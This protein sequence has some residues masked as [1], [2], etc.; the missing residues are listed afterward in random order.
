MCHFLGKLIISRLWCWSILFCSHSATISLHRRQGCYRVSAGTRGY[1]LWFHLRIFVRRHFPASTT[2]W[3]KTRSE[4]HLW[5]SH[6]ASSLIHK[7]DFTSC[8][9]EMSYFAPKQHPDAFFRHGAAITFFVWLIVTPNI[10]F[11][12]PSM[13]FSSIAQS[14]RQQSTSILSSWNRV[15]WIVGCSELVQRVPVTEPHFFFGQWRP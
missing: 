13:V 3:T 14:L 8:T 6:C 10:S 15:G 2:E 11:P 1:C 12:V 5:A 7:Y 4:L 9:K